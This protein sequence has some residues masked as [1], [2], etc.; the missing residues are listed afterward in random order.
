MHKF[1]VA[2]MAPSLKGLSDGEKHGLPEGAVISA[3]PKRYR[4]EGDDGGGIVTAAQIAM[5]GGQWKPVEDGMVKACILL[6]CL[7]HFLCPE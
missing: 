4:P 7:E 5:L 2:S 3:A 1:D 6:P